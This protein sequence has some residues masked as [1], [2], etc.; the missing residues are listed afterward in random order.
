MSPVALNQRLDYISLCI[1]ELSRAL[2]IYKDPK[3]H[4][5][6]RK[7]AFY[8]SQKKA[9]EIVECAIKVNQAL[10]SSRLQ[11]LAKSYKESFLDLEH[12]GLFS[13][14]ERERLAK[15][16]PFRNRL[17]HDYMELKEAD[18]VKEMEEILKIYPDYI[19]VVVPFVNAA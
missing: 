19:R 12:L 8:A 18:I 5:D 13:K 7:I 6:D 9:E 3:L 4:E 17:A 2:K 14:K 10:L 11:I 16:A 15:T 1:R